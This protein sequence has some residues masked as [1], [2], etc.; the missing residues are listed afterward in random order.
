MNENEIEIEL[1]KAYDQGSIDERRALLSLFNRTLNKFGLCLHLKSV[2]PL[3][4]NI[5][6]LDEPT[7][8]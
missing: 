2:E 8:V 4:F 5:T 7:K 3:D 1:E 6:K